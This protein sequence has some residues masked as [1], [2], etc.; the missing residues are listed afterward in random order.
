[1]GYIQTLGAVADEIWA[2]DMPE[3]LVVLLMGSKVAA[4]VMELMVAAVDLLEL[5]QLPY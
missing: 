2:V 3:L 5:G 4:L 1:M